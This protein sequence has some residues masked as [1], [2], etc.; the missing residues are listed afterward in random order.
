[1]GANTAMSLQAISKL[2]LL[3]ANST[4]KKL[5][6]TLVRSSNSKGSDLTQWFRSF[7]KDP[8][9]GSKISEKWYKFFLVLYVFNYI[10]WW[11]K[12]YSLG[13]LQFLNNFLDCWIFSIDDK[14][15]LFADQI[16]YLLHFCLVTLK[17]LSIRRPLI[18]VSLL[19]ITVSS[20]SACITTAKS[21]VTF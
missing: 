16:L 5:Q 14:K 15:S 12:W 10:K 11:N 1:M 4:T 13:L 2:G 19:F 18:K 8:L 21:T 7:R 6:N 9:F 20:A 3:W 17:L